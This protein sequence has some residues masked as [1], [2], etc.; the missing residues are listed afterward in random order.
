[1]NKEEMVAFTEPNNSKMAAPFS[2]GDYSFATN[3]HIAIRIPRLADVAEAVDDFNIRVSLL[4]ENCIEPDMESALI[5]IPEFTTPEQPPCKVRRGTGKKIV[6][7]RIP[8]GCAGF[9]SHYMAM[10][11]ALPGAKIAPTGP[12]TL[13]YFKWDEG[14]G[15]LMPMRK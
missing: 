13:A 7:E 9:A 1:M 10:I 6:I 8:V 15:L 14:E 11:K 3:G 12:E 5:E 2:L 4:F